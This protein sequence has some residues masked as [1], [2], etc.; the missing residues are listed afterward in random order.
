MRETSPK[1]LTTNSTDWGQQQ[2]RQ[3]GNTNLYF[4]RDFTAS[5]KQIWRQ[6][7]ILNSVSAVQLLLIHTLQFKQRCKHKKYNFT[8]NSLLLLTTLFYFSIVVVSSS[9]MEWMVTIK[10]LKYKSRDCMLLIFSFSTLWYV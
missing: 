5:W 9:V 10:K 8:F 6:C 7:N 4:L 2:A 3:P 1:L